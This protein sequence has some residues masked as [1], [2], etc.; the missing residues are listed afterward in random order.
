MVAQRKQERE[1][2]GEKEREKE[3][4]RESKSLKDLFSV[5]AQQFTEF[6]SPV[7]FADY[8]LEECD[9]N[10]VKTVLSTDPYRHQMLVKVNE[11]QIRH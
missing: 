9:L 8:R 6:K 11:K 3:S 10:S 1:R 5:E 7:M 2:E 4:E